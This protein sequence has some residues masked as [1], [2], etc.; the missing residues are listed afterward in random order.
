MKIINLAIFAFFHALSLRADC[1]DADYECYADFIDEFGQVI[2][3]FNYQSQFKAGCCYHP[4]MGCHTCESYEKLFLENCL[5]VKVTGD[6]GT[7]LP[8]TYVLPL[9]SG[10][11]L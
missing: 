4:W 10:C 1:A 2:P 9:H 6:D 7:K 8:A 5:D 11:F 3:T